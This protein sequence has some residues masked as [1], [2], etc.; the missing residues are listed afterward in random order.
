MSHITQ[1]TLKFYRQSTAPSFVQV[2][3]ILDSLLVLYNGKL[4]ANNISVHRQYRE[5]PPILCLAGDLRQIFANIIANAVDAMKS[6]GFR[7][8][9]G[10]A[11][12]ST[13]VIKNNPAYVLQLPTPARE[14]ML[15]RSAKFMNHSLRP[16][17]RPA[18][19]LGCGCLLNSS[20]ACKAICG[21]QA[22][23][24]PTG[25]V[26]PSPFSYPL[27]Y[28]SR[29][30]VAEQLLNSRASKKDSELSLHSLI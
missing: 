3:E 18:P 16:K 14:W 29:E 7:S 15:E 9:C 19:G 12:R 4:L 20:N 11:H 23:R 1:Q 25:V 10:L 22:R 27:S 30:I 28:R 2:S 6:G 5:G 13:G 24:A 8:P 17:T 26:R 21:Y